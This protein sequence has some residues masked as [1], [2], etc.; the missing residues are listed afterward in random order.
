MRVNSMS[1]TDEFKITQIV[2]NGQDDTTDT[3][4]ECFDRTGLTKTENH[5]KRFQ[6]T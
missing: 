3:G 2:D 5:R 6:Q 4:R 1:G